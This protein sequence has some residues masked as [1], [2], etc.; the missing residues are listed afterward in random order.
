MMYQRFEKRKKY[1][2]LVT[3]SCFVSVVLSVTVFVHNGLKQPYSA[4]KAKHFLQIFFLHMT[5]FKIASCG[6]VRLG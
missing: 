3:S 5:H 4:N 1:E 2:R 6:I